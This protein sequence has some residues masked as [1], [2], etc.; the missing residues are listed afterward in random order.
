MIHK[1]LPCHTSLE[2]AMHAATKLPG[3]GNRCVFDILGAT[4]GYRKGNPS[5][6]FTPWIANRLKNA[7]I[8]ALIETENDFQLMRKILGIGNAWWM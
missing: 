3:L 6:C 5:G 2:F 8:F 7:I 4:R 1:Y